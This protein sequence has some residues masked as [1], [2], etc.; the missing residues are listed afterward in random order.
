MIISYFQVKSQ[1]RGVEHKK[2]ENTF[3]RFSQ[4]SMEKT[5]INPTKILLKIT[6]RKNTTNCN[7]NSNEISLQYTRILEK[8][9][10][11]VPA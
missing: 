1:K 6:R 8:C 3:Q 4:T 5:T 7:R 10:C 11:L 9:I 2:H